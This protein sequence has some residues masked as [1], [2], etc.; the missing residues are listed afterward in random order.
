MLPPGLVRIIR[1]PIAFALQVLCWPL[2]WILSIRDLGV[3]AAPA[4]E[5]FGW[6]L[7]KRHYYGPIPS[8]DEL[9]DPLLNEPSELPGLT[10]DSNA[11]R[12]LVQNHLRPF[13]QEF[14]RE[15]P[16]EKPLTPHGYY[17]INGSYMAVDAHMYWA[18][19]RHFRPSRIIEIGAG[20]STVVAAAACQKNASQDQPRTELIAIDPYPHPAVAAGLPGL[21][22][23]IPQRI[24]DV[25]MELFTSLTDGDFLF[26]DSTHV[27]RPGGDVQREY[28]EILPR[29]KPG[30]FVH[31][32][33]VHLPGTYPR[34]YMNNHWY[35]NEQ[36]LLQAFLAF[37]DR[38][39]VLWPGALMYA[40]HRSWM[41]EVF[42][43]IDAM[44]KQ[45]PLAEPS[46]F[47]MRV[48]PSHS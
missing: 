24:Q 16:I 25:P 13:I 21:S 6:V 40:E 20:M 22:K 47:W 15:Y 14:S 37:N 2:A 46:A 44:R 9:A 39:R 10:I 18:L 5:R 26:I 32:H 30:V 36:F 1:P 7:L 31:I 23:L 38:F 29:L 4:F 19:I 42:P 35:W 45:F 8:P 12:Q 33:D 17:L 11:A 28:L 3:L 34:V 43:E 27:L 48:A 41:H